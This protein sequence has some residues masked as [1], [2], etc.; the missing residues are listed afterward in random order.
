[1]ADVVRD[2][3]ARSLRGLAHPL[4]MQVLRLLQ[5]D[6]PATATS[7]AERTG[8]SSGTLSWHLRQLAEHGFIEEDAERGNKRERWWRAKRGT[9]R[10]ESA[11]FRH[12]PATSEALDIVLKDM[13]EHQFR[14]LASYLS[15]DWGPAWSSAATMSDWNN[16]R[17]TP[18]QLQALN[19]ELFAVVERHRP[20]DPAPDAETVVVQIQSFPRR[21]GQS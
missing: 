18:A 3:D 13:L 20:V 12:D 5:S 15:E 6:G 7:L 2:L 14:R 11:Q 19:D 10:L 8:E 4:R 17:M 9:T 1:M 16:L 21:G